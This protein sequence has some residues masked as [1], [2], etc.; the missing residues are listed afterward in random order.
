MQK[1]IMLVDEPDQI[2]VISK[3]SLKVAKTLESIISDSGIDP[4][5]R[6]NNKGFWRIILYRESKKTKQCVISIIVSDQK[7]LENP[8]VSDEKIAEL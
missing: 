6:V 8:D 2:K 7:S 5:D 3:E 4:Y 1:G